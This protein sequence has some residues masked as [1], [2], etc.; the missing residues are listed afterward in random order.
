[1]YNSHITTVS[2]T[3]ERPC[4]AWDRISIDAAGKVRDYFR[5]S[6]HIYLESD[7]YGGKQKA[8]TVLP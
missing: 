6:T 7:T 3:G 4:E 1:M 8:L 2:G 5:F